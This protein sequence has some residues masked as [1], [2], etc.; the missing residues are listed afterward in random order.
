MREG[1]PRW[2]GAPVAGRTVLV[3]AEQ[4]FGDSIQFV[5]Y[6]PLLARAGARVIVEAPLA[7]HGLLG[8]VEGV[9]TLVDRD[10]PAGERPDYDLQIPMMSLPHAFSTTV[11]SVPAE[12]PYLHVE[13]RL[14]DTVE[15]WLEEDRDR[16]CL[17]VGL[18]WAGSPRNRR[19]AARSVP[20]EVLAPL[21]AL[22]GV[23]F[24]SLQKGPGS[25][26]IE[27]WSGDAGP[28]RNAGPLLDNGEP[29]ERFLDT[30]RLMN[31][32][33]LVISADTATA[34]LAGALGRPVWT[35]LSAVPDWRW[36]FGRDDSP[37]YPTMR[38]Y[39]QG[40]AGD[41]AGVVRAMGDDL[42]RLADS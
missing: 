24:Y 12:I 3:W 29:N 1:R 9:S 5:R 25:E 31:R 30:A 40:E 6:V 32:I 33:D 7:L 13:G 10:C 15:T 41:W 28:V 18:A 27:P 14:P 2:D 21:F 34:H 16:R 23:R 38:L 17:T 8:S 11:E 22:D 35:M 37:W 42:R 36:M 39:R 20:V 26:A 19:D 4:G